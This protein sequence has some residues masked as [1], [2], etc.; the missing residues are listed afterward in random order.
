M[1]N[2]TQ[3]AEYIDECCFAKVTVGSPGSPD[4]RGDKG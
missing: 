3:T 1:Q 2:E 4:A